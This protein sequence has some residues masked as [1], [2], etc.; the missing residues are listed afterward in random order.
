MFLLKQN[1]IIKVTVLISGKEI[2]RLAMS[3]VRSYGS[4]TMN[5]IDIQTD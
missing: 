3:L 1:A 4:K 5:F 2:S